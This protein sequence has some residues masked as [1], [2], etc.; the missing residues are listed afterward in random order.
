MFGWCRLDDIER[1]SDM[2]RH[3]LTL[4]AG[5]GVV[6]DA[7]SPQK[8]KYRTPFDRLE[9]R[10]IAIIQDAARAKAASDPRKLKR[11]TKP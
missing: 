5:P 11:P 9:A 7:T 8:R 1:M 4:R 10:R 3:L 2:T 6:V